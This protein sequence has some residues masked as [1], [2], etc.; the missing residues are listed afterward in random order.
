DLRLADDEGRA[1]PDLVAGTSREDADRRLGGALPEGGRRSRR[2]AEQ[3]LM[4]RVTG[5]FKRGNERR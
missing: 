2:R 5:N 1:R 3:L 4:A